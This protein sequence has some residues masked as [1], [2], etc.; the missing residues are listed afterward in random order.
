MAEGYNV[1]FYR[2]GE[3]IIFHLLKQVEDGPDAREREAWPLPPD[4]C[5]YVSLSAIVRPSGIGPIGHRQEP[6]GHLE[7]A[8]KGSK[9]V[10]FRGGR[11]PVRP[12][13]PIGSGLRKQTSETGASSARATTEA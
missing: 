7:K 9:V 12:R 3:T 5:K 13:A 2:A 11:Q 1:Q 10:L 4:N 6:P 8:H